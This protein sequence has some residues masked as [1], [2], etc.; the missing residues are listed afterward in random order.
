[1]PT[2]D[3]GIPVSEVIVQRP[4]TDPPGG[5]VYEQLWLGPLDDAAKPFERPFLA[6]VAFPGTSEQ[7]IAGETTR[8]VGE[9]SVIETPSSRLVSAW[10]PDGWSVSLASDG[11]GAALDEVVASM[12]V[13]ADGIDVAAPDGLQ[14]VASELSTSTVV[15]NA[16]GAAD[17]T[18][19]NGDLPQ[20]M[21]DMGGFGAT[22]IWFSQASDQS[23]R[24]V[25]IGDHPGLLYEADD[26]L[27]V[28]WAV[29]GIPMS[30]R[31]VGFDVD[32][33]L[34]V[35]RSIRAASPDAWVAWVDAGAPSVAE[36]VTV[37]T[38][39]DIVTSDPTAEFTWSI[40]VTA[41]QLAA[42]GWQAY[43]NQ[44]GGWPLMFVRSPADVWTV[45]DPSVFNVAGSCR[46]TPE[47]T[48]TPE[49]GTELTGW[50]TTSCGGRSLPP[51]GL[52][53]MPGE[54][55]VDADPDDGS[56]TVTFVLDT[57]G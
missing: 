27:A 7:S 28:E 40:T 30:V 11:S 52:D 57:D 33:T 29:D 38:Q 55:T 51:D 23:G 5:Q 50:T 17:D 45:A 18:D 48:A 14:L 49:G 56:A 13:T 54:V 21:V 20:W 41:D 37:T 6:V 34:A 47:M 10:H 22:S 25:T 42:P 9:W 4:E 12:T 39:A 19:D 46:L 8:Q 2:D 26:G 24:S 36:S 16:F 43:P 53:E 35:A 1:M 31:T 15:V 32:A 3:L 44:D